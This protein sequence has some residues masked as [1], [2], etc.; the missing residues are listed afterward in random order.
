MIAVGVAAAAGV[1]GW[2]G[3]RAVRARI[4]GDAARWVGKRIQRAQH[5]AFVARLRGLVFSDPFRFMN[6]LCSKE[7]EWFA[8]GLWKEVGDEV[9]RMP[10]TGSQSVLAQGGV[11]P[12]AIRLPDEGMAVEHVRLNNGYVLAIVRLP[13]PM[14][15]GESYL[16]GVALPPD[17]T[18][19]EDIARAR[20]MVRFFVLNKWQGGRGTDFCQWTADD[21]ELTYNVGAPLDA[22]GFALAVQGKMEEERRRK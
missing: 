19:K 2:I 10:G 8:R 20:R 9:A 21:K 13:K 7:A 4:L 17:E 22:N 3:L 6:M 12:H 14:V 5:R 16:A 18:L 11:E 15:T 1:A